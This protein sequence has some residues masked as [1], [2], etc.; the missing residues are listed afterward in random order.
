[1]VVKPLSESFV[2]ETILE[3]ANRSNFETYK[4]E[5]GD[6]DIVLSDGKYK[7]KIECK[8]VQKAKSGKYGSNRNQKAYIEA[9]GQ[10][11]KCMKK[12]GTVYGI[13]FPHTDFFRRRVLEELPFVRKKLSLYFYFV[14]KKRN[15]YQLSPNAKEPKLVKKLPQTYR[16]KYQR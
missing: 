11:V 4:K 7:H 9:L 10:I 8:G 13:A 12:E 1:M 3:L 2:K 16:K 5:R 15:V 14:D 6:P